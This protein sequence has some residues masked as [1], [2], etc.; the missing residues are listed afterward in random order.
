M[1]RSHARVAFLLAAL[2]LVSL[3]VRG[4]VATGFPPY[5]SFSPGTFDTV[6][7]A[8]LNVHFT[9]PI[10]SKAGRGLPFSYALTYDSSFWF[11]AVSWMPWGNGWGWSGGKPLPVMGYINYGTTLQSCNI[12]GTI[13]YYDQ[14]MG[15]AYNDTLGTT[16]LFPATLTVSNGQGTPCPSP[17]PYTGTATAGDGSGYTISVSAAPW[18]AVT[19]RSGVAIYTPPNNPDPQSGSGEMTDP[20]GNTITG[21]YVAPTDTFTDTLQTTALTITDSGSPITKRTFAY[22]GPSGAASV[23]MKY[24]TVSIKTNFGCSGITEYNASNVPLVTEIDL[25]DQGPTRTISTSSHTRPRPG[26]PATPQP[27]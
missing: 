10:I 20:N 14:Y 4:Q 6:N 3:T 21:S 9:I 19:S 17:P 24:T 18:A 11:P 5:G 25:A 27:A 16:H 23:T 15:F 1:S 13:Y 22:T 2:L 8:N 7:N 12:Q 26:I